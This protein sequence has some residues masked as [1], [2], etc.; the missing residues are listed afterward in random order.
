MMDATYT[1]TGDYNKVGNTNALKDFLVKKVE[2]QEKSSLEMRS[3]EKK[4]AVGLTQDWML[5]LS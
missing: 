1:Y 2:R 4:W 3:W 5:F